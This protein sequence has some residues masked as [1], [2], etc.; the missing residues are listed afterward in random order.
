M[1]KCRFFLSALALA[2][3]L[4]LAAPSALAFQTDAKGDAYATVESLG[5]AYQSIADTF[6]CAELAW[7]G[8]SPRGNVL[9]LEYVPAGTKVESWTRLFTVTV[10][11][12]PDDPKASLDAM[13]RLMNGL[14]S[15]AKEHGKIINSTFFRN[16]K[17]EPGAF[18]EYEIGDGALKEHNV[19][20]FMR[21]S[22][23]TATFLQIQA[24]GAQVFDPADAVK[25]LGLVD[26]PKTDVPADT[27]Q[28]A[29]AAQ[30]SGK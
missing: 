30:P 10:Y 17:E 29:A 11:S 21:S 13:T 23:K 6:G 25:M 1:I 26:K 15:N 19:G 16:A 20:V 5:K 2:A 9:T 12:L 8:M 3:G 24:R 27:D 18:L 7:G 14:L 28:P 22:D 4:F